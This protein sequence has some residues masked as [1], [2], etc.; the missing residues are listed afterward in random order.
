MANVAARLCRKLDVDCVDPVISG[1]SSDG[2]GRLTMRAP[3]GFD[4]YAELSSPGSMS[5]MYFFYPPL[6]GDRALPGI[7]VVSEATLQ[8]FAGL[9]GVQFLAERSVIFL[10]AHD[11]SDKPASGVSFSSADADEATVPFYLVQKVPTASASA[12]DAEGRGG[13]INVRI[14]AVTVD[15]QLSDG[16]TVAKVSLFTRQNEV[17]YTSVAPGPG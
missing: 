2:N 15:G 5:G 7:P 3:G 6:S 16:E 8:R 11:C 14:G 12:T 9:A 13:L 17:T 1:L 10:G 4:G